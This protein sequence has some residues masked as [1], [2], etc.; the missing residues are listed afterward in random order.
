MPE[1]NADSFNVGDK[2]VY[3]HHSGLGFGEHHKSDAGYG[4]ITAEMRGLDLHDGQQVILFEMDADSGW[5]IIEWMD[6]TGLT[7]LTTVEPTFFDAYF[8]L[9]S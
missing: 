8:N 7:R 9:T 6:D 1:F 4:E 5:P 2:Y 3:N